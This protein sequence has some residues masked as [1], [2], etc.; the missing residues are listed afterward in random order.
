MVLLFTFC[1]DSETNKQ[2]KY[3]TIK[4]LFTRVVFGSSQLVLLTFEAK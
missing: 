2:F 3:S 1:F 4:R